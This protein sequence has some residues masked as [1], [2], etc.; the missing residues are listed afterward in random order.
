MCIRD[1]LG[2]EPLGHLFR[3]PDVVGESLFDQLFQHERLKQLQRHLLG[4]AALIHLQFRANDDNATAGVV[5]ALAQQVLAEP[6]LL[7]AQQDVYKRQ[8]LLR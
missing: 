6:A 4:E 5:H 7:A 2:I 8:P 1:S 3:L